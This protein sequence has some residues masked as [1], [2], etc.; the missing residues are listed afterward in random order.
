MYD[1]KGPIITRILIL[2]TRLE[3]KNHQVQIKLYASNWN[4]MG[5]SNKA[6]N[7]TQ[8]SNMNTNFLK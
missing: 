5:T 4:F 7:N 2:G 8:D 6:L 1:A 3:G